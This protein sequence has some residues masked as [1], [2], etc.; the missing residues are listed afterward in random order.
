MRC[1]AWPGRS[2]ACWNCAGAVRQREAALSRQHLLLLQH[3]ALLDTQQA[4]NGLDGDLAAVFETL[5][6]GVMRALPQ[7]EGGAIALIDGPD[8]VDHAPRDP[9]GRHGNRRVPIRGSLAGRSVM[10]GRPLL[11]ADVRAEADGITRESPGRLGLRSC[12]V[13]PIARFGQAM[14][15]LELWSGRPEAFGE[16]DLQVARLF[17]GEAVTGLAETGEA[18]ALKAVQDS[19]GRYRSV[20]DSI[21]DFALIVTDR[22]GTVTGWN[23]GAER[24]LGWS[25]GEMRDQDVERIFTPEDRAVSRAR[26]EMTLSLEEGRAPDERWHLRHDGSRFWSSGEMM[27]LRDGEGH[28]HG[29][30]KVL[31]DRTAEHLAGRALE[32]AEAR[33]R[34]SEDHHKHTVELNP[35][36]PWTCDPEGNITS[37]SGRWLDL[38][39]QGAGRAGRGRLDQG[40]PPRRRRPRLGGL[41]RPARVGRTGRCRLPH[42]GRRDGRLSLDEGPGLSPPQPGRVDPALVRRRRGRDTIAGPRRHACGRAR[43]PT[44]PWRRTSGRSA[45]PWCRPTPRWNSGSR[46]GRGIATASGACRP[47]SCWSGASMAGSRP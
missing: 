18:D 31:R 24:I 8:L 42:P 19:E 3:R 32:S 17:A 12:L 33:L 26:T 39:G 20:F 38:T 34:E 29:F 35:A 11:I 45:R 2:S 13:V 41:R 9:A 46:S 7:A 21:T 25:R 43:P 22:G 36:V 44:G 37:Y 15:V 1:G 6:G 30:V 10:T 4:V 40:A 23:T 14:G 5:V 47:T 28:H 27:P 16:D